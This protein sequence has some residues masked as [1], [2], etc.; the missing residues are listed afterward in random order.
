MYFMRPPLGIRIYP[1]NIV[2]PKMTFGQRIKLVCPAQLQRSRMP[3]TVPA[4]IQAHPTPAKEDQNG[5]KSGRLLNQI[6]KREDGYN[7]ASGEYMKYHYQSIVAVCALQ[8]LPHQTGK[9]QAE[10]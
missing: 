4:K 10:I 5:V 7:S 1:M 3:K 8:C 9:E 2:T 6:K